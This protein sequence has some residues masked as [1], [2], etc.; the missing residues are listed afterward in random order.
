MPFRVET[1][2]CKFG[3][4]YSSPAVSTTHYSTATDKAHARTQTSRPNTY[5]TPLLEIPTQDDLTM[6]RPVHG[7][8]R[9]TLGPH[10]VKRRGDALAVHVMSVTLCQEQRRVLTAETVD[11]DCPRPRAR[12][13]M[14]A[15]TTRKRHTYVEN[16]R[17]DTRGFQERHA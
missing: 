9:G 16:P 6:Q 10:G 7:R 5:T 1:P 13:N 2:P 4:A 17:L 8:A 15:C 12:G 14:K 11:A 3:D